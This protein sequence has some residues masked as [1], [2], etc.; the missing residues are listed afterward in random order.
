MGQKDK[1]YSYVLQASDSVYGESMC[2]SAPLKLVL[3]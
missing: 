1:E 2:R 3:D